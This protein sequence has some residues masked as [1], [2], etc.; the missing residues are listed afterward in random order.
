MAFNWVYLFWYFSF[1]F[2]KFLDI[3]QHASSFCLAVTR[4][5]GS[6]QIDSNRFFTTVFPVSCILLTVHVHWGNNMFTIVIGSRPDGW[7]I[8]L[9]RPHGTVLRVGT[10]PFRN[11]FLAFGPA[12]SI[13]TNI[14]TFVDPVDWHPC[15]FSTSRVYLFWIYQ[16]ATVV[17][18]PRVQRVQRTLSPTSPTDVSSSASEP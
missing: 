15:K 14:Y 4:C 5:V 12:S 16:P 17:P 8:I 10:L 9:S 11:I 7:R 6:S 3:Q 2:T 18:S 1:A 13:R